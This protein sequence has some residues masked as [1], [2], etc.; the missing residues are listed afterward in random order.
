[1]IRAAVVGAAGYVGG[2]LLRLLLGHPRVQ[3]TQAVSTR[4]PGRRVDGVH[5]NLRGQT[6]LAFRREEDL[7]DCDVLLLATP[8]RTTMSLLPKLASRAG[9]VIDLSAD[10]RLRDPA[11]YA[12]WYGVE[13]AATGL[14]PEFVTGCPELFRE[15]L[16]D[17]DRISVP[18]CTATAATLALHPLA[19]A[20]MIE[21]LVV[22]DGRSGSSGAGASAGAAG[23][24]ANL[25]AERSGA[26]RVFAPLGH[27]HQA[28]VA[29]LT[30]LDVRMTATGVEAVRGVQVV[31]HARA[32][33]PLDERAV[34][35]AYRERYAGEPFVRV[36]THR[37]G[38][39][40]YPEPKILLGSNYCD[41]GFAVDPGGGQVT[42]IAAL[43]NLVK[44]AAGNA[45]Q[46]L[47][48]RMDWP[49]RL[50]LEFPG[51]HPI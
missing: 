51:L 37:H 19:T 48:I 50:G 18:G 8:H 30:G 5:P 17:A 13:H 36:V 2:E 28:E 25:H 9:V 10:F 49:E 31:C 47:N 3:V 46:C 44:G 38:T 43:D 15:A 24:E 45:V 6:D 26:M 22:V 1:V 35:R 41:V 11:A 29:Q 40:R 14:L 34:R 27:R 23:S 33:A 4:L 12:R 32:S 16:R 20:R 39:Y 42:L 21:P 7:D